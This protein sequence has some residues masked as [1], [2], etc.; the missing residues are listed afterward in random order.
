MILSYFV[1]SK[2][3]RIDDYQRENGKLITHWL[4]QNNNH[5]N[6]GNLYLLIKHRTNRITE[7][8][9]RT[10]R[11]HRDMNN[12]ALRKGR[13]T[14]VTE[15]FGSVYSKK[16]KIIKNQ[17]FVLFIKLNI[18]DSGS[19]A[20]LKSFCDYEQPLKFLVSCSSQTEWIW[21]RM[22]VV[23]FENFQNEKILE[24][25]TNSECCCYWFYLSCL[26]SNFQSSTLDSPSLTQYRYVVLS[27]FS[28]LQKQ[29]SS[30]R[31][32]TFSLFIYHSVHWASLRLPHS[33]HR[34]IHPF[35]LSISIFVPSSFE[36]VALAI[37][38]T[39]LPLQTG[40]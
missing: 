11:N 8:P 3:S 31:M 23:D 17:I 36:V 9:Y 14:I 4:S 10:I 22:C 15:C 35:I 21:K 28:D 16:F 24:H 34:N 12:I 27:L 25:A 30:I 5:W 18:L 6:I 33:C 32:K 40:R 20:T 13:L 29:F 7:N 2:I 19:S 38:S 39:Y 26:F 37:H 1:N